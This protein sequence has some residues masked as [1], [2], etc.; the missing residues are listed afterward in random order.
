MS[1]DLNR[2]ITLL[3]AQVLLP[4]IWLAVANPVAAANPAAADPAKP[5][6]IELKVN[7]VSGSAEP[8]LTQG[9]EGTIVLSWQEPKGNKS[10][11]RFSHLTD[12]GWSTPRTVAAGA[13]WFVNWAD[14]PSVLAVS[15]ELWAAHWLSKRPGGT[16]SYD[17]SLA[18]STDG[19]E[20]WS[21]ATTPHHDNTATE[22]GFVSLYP[23]A[24]GVGVV[25]LD[26]R[27]T[28][29]AGDEVAHPGEH[30]QEHGSGG[31]T[32]RHANFTATGAI[33]EE[34]ELD[35]LVCDC[36]QT[37]VALARQ[38]PVVVYRDR[39][40]EEI[41][42]IYIAR[43]VDGEWLAGQAVH[44]DGWK[45]TGCPVNGPAVAA[46]GDTVAV[47]WFTMADDIPRV[48]FARS[49]DG[50]ASFGAVVEVAEHS[51][52]GRVDLVLLENGH[53]VVSWLDQLPGGNGEFRLR[54]IAG[55]GKTAE[56]FSVTPMQTGR[57]SGFP[58]M[59]SHGNDLVL[60]WTESGESD[61][62]R[63]GTSVKSTRIVWPDGLPHRD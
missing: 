27:N 52:L 50:G 18:L 48:R 4:V 13:N 55:D 3:S 41:R 51:P 10:L 32:L 36:C 17:V 16:Y 12:A 44:A 40:K 30:A 49:E 33:S 54:T 28:L 42:D 25:W 23:A 58:Q 8:N 56:P 15:D 29:A 21:E 22:H 19:G 6:M 2:A 61:G 53:A 24:A 57:P 20:H 39:T 59:Q 35:D 31:M 60:A 1:I 46:Q 38:G 14:F 11:L 26:G 62:S 47:A 45:I 5:E 63:S 34:I 7:A 43:F 9:P 37:S